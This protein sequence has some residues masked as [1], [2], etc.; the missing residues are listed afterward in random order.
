MKYIIARAIVLIIEQIMIYYLTLSDVR[1][2]HLFND[3][4]YAHLPQGCIY[5]LYSYN[6]RPIENCRYNNKTWC[7]YYVIH[8]YQQFTVVYIFSR[9][10]YINATL[11]FMN[12]QTWV[13]NPLVEVYRIGS[14][15]TGA[16]R[17][18]SIILFILQELTV[19]CIT[20]AVKQLQPKEGQLKLIEIREN[21][22]VHT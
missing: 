6:L 8:I 12:S 5:F 13:Y 21:L 2:R 17:V 15:Y 18:L 20:Y 22:E 3:N 11:T 1:S 14:L 16:C 7:T 9:P 19:Y 10:V 4:H